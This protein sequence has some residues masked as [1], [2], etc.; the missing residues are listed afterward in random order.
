[1]DVPEELAG[2]L[3]EADVAGADAVGG[4][5]VEAVVLQGS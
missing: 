3:V 4:D 1:M 5:V 2:A